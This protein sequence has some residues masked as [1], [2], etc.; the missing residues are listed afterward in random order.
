MSDHRGHRPDPERIELLVE[1]CEAISDAGLRD[2]VIELLRL[3]LELN[4]SG[5]R[6]MLDAA[7]GA[8]HL[9]ALLAAWG[10]DAEVA[11]L[12]QLHGLEL[13][14]PQPAQA[15]PAAGPAGFVPLETLITSAAH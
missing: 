15:A 3:V 12:L 10:R 14:H 9:E 4:G 6:R 1:R 7:A 11:G 13:P 2:Q 8:P 5:I